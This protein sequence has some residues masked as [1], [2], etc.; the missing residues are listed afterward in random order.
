MSAI[1]LDR[2]P[3]ATCGL[4]LYKINAREQLIACEAVIFAGGRDAV[5]T[6]LRRAAISGWVEVEP[7]G[8]LP[9]FYA[10]VLTSADG[11]WEASVALDRKSYASL[12]NR[13][14]RCKLN[15]P[16]DR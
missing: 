12:K 14:M 15:T 9:D 13:W 7:E 5:N 4:R 1:G 10:D 8:P 6:V 16:N 2:L 3:T 11:A